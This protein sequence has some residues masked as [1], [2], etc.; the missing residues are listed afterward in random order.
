MG[1]SMGE[2][3]DVTAGVMRLACD[4]TIEGRAIATVAREKE[5]GD[6]NFDLGDDW[7][8]LD[9]GTSAL[10]KIRDGTIW[11]LEMVGGGPGAAY[12]MAKAAE[13]KN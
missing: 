12:G 1:I 3:E 4:E 8:G 10:G 2:I 11:G 9:A 13:K 6:K 5:A 7:E